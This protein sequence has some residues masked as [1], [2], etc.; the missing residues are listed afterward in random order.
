M[1][2]WSCHCFN[3]H[4]F[5]RQ[6]FLAFP[7]ASKWE[8]FPGQALSS[9]PITRLFDHLLKWVLY[10]PLKFPWMFTAR[11]I[12]SGPNK[13]TGVWNICSWESFPILLAKSCHPSLRSS[14]D[15]GEWKKVP[16]TEGIK[17]AGLVQGAGLVGCCSIICPWDSVT[18][19]KDLRFP[20]VASGRLT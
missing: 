14:N 11:I 16:Y 7:S 2:C 10:V 19:G 6:I 12:S 5:E 18:L 9:V 17:V 13:R 8:L 20:V 3:N 1:T 4:P 15:S